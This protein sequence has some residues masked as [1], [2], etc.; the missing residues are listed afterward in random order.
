MISTAKP[1]S[2]WPKPSLQEKCTFSPRSSFQ[3]L[4]LTHRQPSLVL[5]SPGFTSLRGCKNYRSHQKLQ[6]PGIPPG[7]TTSLQLGSGISA[8][9]RKLWLDNSNLPSASWVNSLGFPEEDLKTC[10]DTGGFGLGMLNTQ[11][12]EC[13]PKDYLGS[14][15]LGHGQR[16][17]SLFFIPKCSWYHMSQG[18]V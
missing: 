8:E 7:A 18:K 14:T 15:S 3:T 9:S 5:S 16:P 12:S 6:L 2:A 17:S 4:R 13:L 11:C 10:S 1:P